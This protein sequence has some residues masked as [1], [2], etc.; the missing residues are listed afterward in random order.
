MSEAQ[1]IKNFN[2]NHPHPDVAGVKSLFRFSRIDENHIEYLSDLFVDG[3]LYHSMP[4]NFNDPF[5]CKPFFNLPKSPSKVKAIRKHL[6]NVA[7]RSGHTRKSAE[8]LISGSMRKRGF[9]RE[10][11]YNSINKNLSKVRI[12]SFT[13]K[14][15]NLLFWSHYADS[16]KG[17]CVEYDASVLPISYAFKVQ[18]KDEY[19]EATYPP[20][21]NELG[22][23]PILIKSKA[24][25]YEEEYRIIFIPEAKSLPKN[26]GT[27]LLLDG[28]EIKNI[29]LGANMSDDHKKT[30]VKMIATG[31]FRPGIWDVDLSKSSFKLK[32]NKHKK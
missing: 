11:I 17:F 5:E 1:D 22:F 12:S 4:E 21:S 29:F 26:D 10:T 14:K 2:R 16:H 9:I 25:E 15:E 31:P 8:S 7:M 18:Y 20:P 27:S 24:W 32:F 6:I 30:I 28:S 13:I 3:K 23:I 19:P